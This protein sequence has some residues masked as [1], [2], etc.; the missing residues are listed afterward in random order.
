[1]ASTSCVLWSGSTVLSRSCRTSVTSALPSH[2]PSRLRNISRRTC[3]DSTVKILPKD[4]MMARRDV[5]SSPSSSP[6]ESDSDARISCFVF[7]SIFAS[8]AHLDVSASLVCCS[9]C[10]SA[11]SS[12]TRR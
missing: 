6:S 4:S 9:D 11:S 8:P 3:G 10:T 5:P 12:L 7:A 1:M 2:F